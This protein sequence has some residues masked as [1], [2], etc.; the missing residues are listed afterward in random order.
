MPFVFIDEYK[1]LLKRAAYTPRIRMF[2]IVLVM[3]IKEEVSNEKAN[4][5]Y[6]IFYF[7]WSLFFIIIVN[8]R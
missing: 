6:S 5:R 4:T 8:S 3:R 7:Y 1:V 2:L